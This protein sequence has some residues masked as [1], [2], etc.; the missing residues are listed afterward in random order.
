MRIRDIQVDGFGAWSNFTVDKMSDELTVFY[1]PN[2]AGKTTL[3]QFIRAVLYGFSPERRQ[4]YLPPLQGGSPGGS[5]LI[6]SPTHGG[7]RVGR[8]A[9]SGE[10]FDAPGQLTLRGLDGEPRNPELLPLVLS[11][12]DEAT[13][14]NV[15]AVGLRE[16]QELGTLDATE[17][18]QLLYNL[19]SG[20]DRVA[21]VEVL[22]DLERSRARILG[23]RGG[24]S[25]LER[26]LSRRARLRDELR[27]AEG[28]GRDW[29]ESAGQ[30]ASVL[31]EIAAQRREIEQ[32]EAEVRT[33]DAA[34]PIRQR[35]DAR[36]QLIEK[37]DACHTK[38]HLQADTLERLEALNRQLKQLRGKHE[39]IQKQRKQVKQEAADLPV[40]RRLVDAAPRIEAITEQLPWIDTLE[41][42]I[43]AMQPEVGLRPTPGKLPP[44]GTLLAVP[45]LTPGSTPARP[46][47]PNDP[48]VTPRVVAAL[49]M[50]AKQVRDAARLVKEA[51]DEFERTQQ[52]AEEHS[53]DVA[54]AL[55]QLGEK[56]LGRALEAAGTLVAKLRRRLQ[57]EEKLDRTLHHRDT[58]ESTI[59]E[60]MDNKALP[61]SGLVWSGVVFVIG[62]TMVLAGFTF[63]DTSTQT[64]VLTVLSGILMVVGSSV[65]KVWLE[66]QA[67]RDLDST[68]RQLKAVGEQL[69]KIEEERHE[70]DDQIPS[71][72]GSLDSR[73]LEA[74]SQLER[75]ERLA[76]SDSGRLSTTRRSSDAEKKLENANKLLKESRERW[77]GVLRKFKLPETLT[78]SEIRELAELTEEQEQEA[79][80][81]DAKRQELDL[82][83]REL[84]A[85]LGRIE[86][87]F[88]ELQIKPVSDDPRARVHQLTSTLKEQRALLGRRAKLASRHKQLGEELRKL[89]DQGRRVVARRRELF[90]EAGVNDEQELRQQDERK[91]QFAVLQR[92]VDEESRLI[93]AAL[94]AQGT[95]RE[96]FAKLVES[97]NLEG[98]DNRRAKLLQRTNDAQTQL[99]K[100]HQRQGALDQELKLAGEDRRQDRL[101]VELAAID[102]RIGKTVRRWRELNVASRILE[103]LRHDFEHDR[104]PETLSEASR[105]LDQLTEGRYRR[106]WTPFGEPVLWIDTN[107]GTSVPLDVLSS[108]TREAVFVCLRLAL[109]SNFARRG[110]SLPL[111]LDD[112]LVNFDVERGSAAARVLQQFAK[113]GRQVLLFTCHEHILEAFEDLGAEVRVLPG[114]TPRRRRQVA[115]PLPVVQ[116]P[117]EPQV[118]PVAAPVPVVVAPPPLPQPAIPAPVIPAPVVIETVRIP[119]PQVTKVIVE[120]ERDEDD[121]RVFA[122]P[123]PPPPPPPE[124]VEDVDEAKRF[125][126]AFWF[127]DED[128]NDLAPPRPQPTPEPTD[129]WETADLWWEGESEEAVA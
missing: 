61:I 21:L 4:R 3:M 115:Q 29:L 58:L 6:E 111:V 108:G 51:K 103:K 55:E 87:M 110:A 95:A 94:E 112:V 35:W 73:L 12:V 124:P 63:A 26:L 23:D 92:Q 18:A 129:V 66:W 64:G 32:F 11:N 90:A 82:R 85:F 104:Q 20:L 49:R 52:H 81:V 114:H 106:I 74:E 50:P 83:E 28:R 101:R 72:G 122:P 79:K 43:R 86:Q 118:A 100:L 88:G 126:S 77:R 46:A 44:P 102:C 105:Y 39:T 99:T 113:Q 22:E 93:E 38:A 36:A 8:R 34:L 60:M 84:A 7:L 47:K 89:S 31:Q 98:L 17:A 120:E 67:N 71:G 128:V 33:L 80:Q 116:A 91:R 69:V 40:N 16:L 24:D 127:E 5:L 107:E 70:L 62:F 68:S 27:E 37:R 19:T 109:A 56:N 96:A 125:W 65:S 13:F 76:A 53:D 48:Q 123:A 10:S 54:D 45:G 59:E 9:V 2:E 97:T 15:F 117:P 121:E 75:L 42:H 57:V 78:P 14:N 41:Q 1:G 25:D 30:R 119:A